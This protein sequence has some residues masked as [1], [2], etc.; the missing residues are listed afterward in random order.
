MD[1]YKRIAKHSRTPA[2][3]ALGYRLVASFVL[4][5]LSRASITPWLQLHVYHFLIGN[6]LTYFMS[7]ISRHV[8][9]SKTVLDSGF[10]A[11]DS[12]FQLLDFSGTFILDSDRWWNSGF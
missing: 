7:N 12:R 4:S 8:R 11:M 3:V 6:E 2:R 9:E 5:K 10:H 1:A